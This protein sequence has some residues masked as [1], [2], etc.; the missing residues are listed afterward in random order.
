M[1]QVQKMQ[2][3][4]GIGHMQKII[5]YLLNI[6]WPYYKFIQIILLYFL[7]WIQ[8]TFIIIIVTYWFL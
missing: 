4:L 3:T 1:S 2:K 5:C 6:M 7:K 8:M